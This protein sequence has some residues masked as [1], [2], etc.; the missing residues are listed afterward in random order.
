MKL[1]CIDSNSILN[2][3]FYGIKLLSTKDGVYTNAVFGYMNIFKKLLDEVQPDAV[4]CAFD[5]P[6]PTFR[7]KRYDGYKAQRKGMPDELASQ[8]PIVKE[9]LGYLGYRIVTLEGYE[10][11]DILGTFARQCLEAG[12]ECVIATGDRD[13]L[14]LVSGATSVLLASTKAGKP[15]TT[16][17]TPEYIRETY[18]I[19]PHQLIDVKALMGD[20]SDNIPGVAG[21]G[22]KGALK[23]ISEFGSLEAIYRD[24]SSLPVSPKLREKL[25]AGRESAWLSRELAEINCNAPLPVCAADCIPGR[26]DYRAARALLSK[27]QMF[28]MID[29]LELPQEDEAPA[30]LSFGDVPAADP[31]PTGN[32]SVLDAMIA[33]E[34]PV[35]LLCTFDDDEP[36]SFFAAAEEVFLFSGEETADHLARLL[37]SPAAKQ[38]SGVKELY[39]F[40]YKHDIPVR[41]IVFDAELAGYLLSPNSTEYSVTR[42]LAEYGIPSPRGDGAALGALCERLKD[43]LRQNGQD[44]LLCDI[45]LPLARVLAQMEMR[46][47]AVDADG[48]SAFGQGLDGKITELE[49]EIYDHAGETFNINSPKQLGV[50]LFERLELPSRRRTKS[51]YSTDAEVL[52][53]LI[54]YHPIISAILEYR[55]LT[56]LRSTYVEGLLRAISPDG[57]IH[58]RFLQTET[59]TGRISSAEPNMQNIPVRTELGSTMR[60]F[61][62]ARKG[63]VLIDADYSQIELRVLAHIADDANMLDAFASGADIHTRTAA[64][65]FGSAPDAVTPQLRSRAK[66]VNFGIVYGIGAYSLSKDIGVSVAEADRYIKQYLNTFSGVRDYMERTVEEAK[67]DGYVTTLFGRRRYLPELQSTNK[68][69]QA[70]GRRVAMNTPIQGTAADIIKLAMIRVSDRL[71]REGLR[72]KLILQVHDELI[73]EAPEEE[74][75]AAAEIL[76]TEM[77]QAAQL[78]VKLK[79]D[80]NA[81][82]TWYDAK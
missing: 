58:T 72:A 21:I 16:V 7:H 65:V 78:R 31:L 79:V 24:L 46:G 27:L 43:E 32:S 62:I 42:L 19:E 34:K 74:A 39:R 38:T 77:E 70:F 13:S 29:R 9:L 18:G 36:V 15:S 41:N 63:H 80:C 56:K 25:E 37:S 53:S 66:A 45:E 60:K 55:K 14:Q 54:A 35:K 44:R 64:Q 5:L 10:A 76:R 3:A 17:C 50:I 51:G 81:G 48:I 69:V 8:M 49:Q 33:G 23:L 28:T 82:T 20:T 4:A 75:Q 52:E 67:R 61:F 40:A 30:Q 59:R 68:N 2:R 71:E 6:I 1:L 22:E 47:F 73:V 12:D 26:A 57:R 11:D